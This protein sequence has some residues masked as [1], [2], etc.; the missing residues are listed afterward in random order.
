MEPPAAPVDAAGLERALAPFGHSRMLPAEAYTSAEVLRWEERA[1]FEG[2]WF[3]AGRASD[4]A[5]PGAQRAVRVGSEG[6]LLVRD[7]GGTL[8]G[9]FNVCRHRGHELLEVGDARQHTVIRCPYHAWVYD[10]DGTLRG[11]A[12][13]EE[14]PAEALAPVAVAEWLGWVFVNASAE[15]TPFAEHAGGLDALLA[16][17]EPERLMVAAREEYEV[18][19]NW[20]IVGENYH[21]CYHCS[22]I[23]PEL[24]RVSPPDSGENLE[25]DGAWVGGFMELLD[26]AET[27]SISGR[28]DG[29]VLP[30]L[31]ER[32]RRQVLY[33]HVFPN[34][35]VSLHPD[36]VLTH[37]LQPTAPDRTTVQCEWLFPPEAVGR[38]G[39][40]PAYAVEF[41]DVTNR[42]DWRACESV[43]RG[44]SSRAFRPGPLSPRED[45]VY[46][47][48]TLVAKGYRDGK[49]TTPSP[50]AAPAAP[51]L[52][53]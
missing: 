34:L 25:P 7:G 47:F 43:Q 10:L 1:F 50:V 14:T 53:S 13:F 52:G 20:K 33:V 22:S 18:R 15:V 16:P 44:V 17:W 12:G 4:V 2:S 28:S 27:M 30:G 31:D 19:A 51:A 35:L 9:F 38:D 36:Y 41:W 23:H 45:A 21:E 26:R 39:F 40:D 48:I 42:E 5:E 46:R 11:A 3:C 37:R 24:C 8:R 6:V 29:V 49:V 32:L